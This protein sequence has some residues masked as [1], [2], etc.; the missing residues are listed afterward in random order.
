MSPSEPVFFPCECA[1]SQNSMHK[2]NFTIFRNVVIV[3]FISLSG[4][5][6]KTKEKKKEI[7]RPSCI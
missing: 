6:K 4:E 2:R 7:H 3:Q 1:S 5:K